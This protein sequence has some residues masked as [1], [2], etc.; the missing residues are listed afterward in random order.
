MKSIQGKFLTIVISGMLIL[1]FAISAI[2]V[3]YISKILDT[4]SDTITEAVAN[5][6]ALRINQKLRD[7]EYSVETMA[8]YVSSTIGDIEQ[9]K[10]ETYINEYISMAEDAFYAIANESD[11]TL[12][13]YLCLAPEISDGA[14][15]CYFARMSSKGEFEELPNL[16][17]T[18]LES[19]PW[20]HEPKR[21]GAPVWF[22]PY[23]D[24]FVKTEVVSYVIPLYSEHNFIGIIGVDLE[25]SVLTE[26]VKEISVYDNGFVF[27]NFYG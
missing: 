8:N 10:D 24:E 3:L 6:E 16:I 23:Y 25:F 22:N 7:V 5:T 2:S 12:A 15:G 17:P 27:I 13:F 20:Y 11:G 9:I 18:D 14:S 19:S 4:D 21:T 1:A 26:M